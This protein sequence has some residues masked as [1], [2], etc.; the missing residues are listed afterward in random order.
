MILPLSVAFAVHHPKFPGTLV[1]QQY[2]V[3]PPAALNLRPTMIA[4]F[5][6]NLHRR[7]IAMHHAKG[8]G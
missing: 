4:S 8:V 1:Q 2:A 7:W 5:P 6:L 3:S